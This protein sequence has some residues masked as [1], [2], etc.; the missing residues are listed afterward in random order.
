MRRTTPR[1]PDRS[2]TPQSNLTTVEHPHGIQNGTSECEQDSRREFLQMTINHRNESGRRRQTF[3]RFMTPS[4]H[5]AAECNTEIERH[6][7][8]KQADKHRNENRMQP[9]RNN[10]TTSMQSKNNK[11]TTEKHC[12]SRHPTNYLKLIAHKT[13]YKNSPAVS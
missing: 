10:E 7:S 13:Q 12:A 9:Q 1:Q 2:R 8:G 5:P 3:G 11:V 4:G 6:L